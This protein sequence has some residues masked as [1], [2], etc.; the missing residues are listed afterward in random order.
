MRQVPA[1][2]D[3]LPCC[4]EQARMLAQVEPHVD[5]ELRSTSQPLSE[6][7]SQLSVLLAQAV[8]APEA[9]VWFV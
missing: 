5:V 9:Q 6:L 2:H 1:A 7:S 8:H 3:A 4:V